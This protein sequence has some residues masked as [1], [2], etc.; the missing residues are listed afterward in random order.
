MYEVCIRGFGQTERKRK[1][2]QVSRPCWRT[3]KKTKTMEHEVTVIPVV[4]GALGI[5]TK[6]RQEYLKPYN[7][8][9]KGWLSHRNS[10]FKP[11]NY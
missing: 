9:K 10:Y 8:E 7:C 5:I 2:R 1:E 3:E 4:I 11:Y 6:D